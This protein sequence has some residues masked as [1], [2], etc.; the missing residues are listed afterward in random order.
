M[1]MHIAIA[2]PIATED[3]ASLLGDVSGLP[4][5][6]AGAPL[7]ASLV[8]ELL[9]RGHRVTAFTTSLGMDVRAGKCLVREAGRFRVCFCPMRKRGFMP[10]DGVVGRAADFF[11]I[12]RQLL[13][14][15]IRAEA[16]DV[17]HAHWSYEFGLAALATGLP[18][19]VTCHDSPTAVLK[20][21][22]T[23]YRLVRY[24]MA[25][26]CLRRAAVV[27]AVSPYLKEAVG[28]LT[29][30]DIAVVENP[31]PKDVLAVAAARNSRRESRES[32]TRLAMVSNGWGT[33]KNPIPAFNAFKRLRGSVFPNLEFHVFGVG[34]GPGEEAERWAKDNDAV[35]GVFFHG[36]V[37]HAELVRALQEMDVLVHPALEESFGMVVAEAM[38]LGLPVV[39]GAESGGVP[40]VIS[41]AGIVTDVRS[42]LAIADAVSSILQN[43]DA[44]KKYSEHGITRSRSVFSLEA[45]AAK[46]ERTYQEALERFVLQQGK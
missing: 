38:A 19:V 5:G 44:A 16:P 30:V 46:Y 17:V 26:A 39:G 45:V 18:T 9:G 23:P 14:A 25:R 1:L 27:T 29:S 8:R 13:A 10:S 34:Y 32:S 41:D 3:I 28:R 35:D 40:W 6:Y 37:P 33:L 4:A 24:F 42:D 15:A 22:P 31:L 11:R 12:E 7:L 36:R 2:G 20:H 21:M 43:P